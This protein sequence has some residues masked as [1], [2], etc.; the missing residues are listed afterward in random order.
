MDELGVR[1]ADRMAYNASGATGTIDPTAGTITIQVANAAIV[2]VTGAC[3]ATTSRTPGRRSPTFSLA[4]GRLGDPAAGHRRG[5]GRRRRGALASLHQPA[6]SRRRDRTGPDR[7]RPDQRRADG[8][9]RVWTDYV[10]LFPGRRSSAAT[11]CRPASPQRADL[12]RPRRQL[13]RARQGDHDLD[14]RGARQHHGTWT[15][16]GD[17]GFA[18][19]WVWTPQDFTLPAPFD[20]FFSGGT[21]QIRYGTT[22]DSTPRPWIGCWLD[23]PPLIRTIRESPDGMS[24]DREAL[25]DEVM[26]RGAIP[27]RSSAESAVQASWRCCVIFCAEDSLRAIAEH[28]P[29]SLATTLQRRGLP[30]MASPDTFYGQLAESE[31]ISLGLAVE[32]ALAA[33]TSIAAALDEDERLPG[34]PV[35]CPPKWAE[36]FEE[37]TR[38]PASED[39]ARHVLVYGHTLATGKPGS[40]HWLAEASPRGAQ[41]ESVVSAENP[42]ADTK[43]SSGADAPGAEPLATGQS[44]AKQPIAGAKD[45]RRD[46]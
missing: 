10:E 15:E 29:P 13:P 16:L 28:L 2:P 31:Q 26:W 5:L 9:E 27:D 34:S 32:R 44:G 4:G 12:A 42:H 7:G 30:P 3:G 25:L 20:R 41:A 6:V 14:L 43:L 21:L 37:D 17:N 8:D 36:L 24:V 19:V 18:D 1:V 35:A 38:T 39:P 23:R 33:C 40:G 45:Q 46:R 11:S 22:S